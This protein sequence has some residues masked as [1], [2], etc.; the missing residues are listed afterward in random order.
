MTDLCAEG[1][2][3]TQHHLLVDAGQNA[4]GSWHVIMREL[5]HN[6]TA[7]AV[8]TP[9]TDEVVLGDPAL[10]GAGSFCIS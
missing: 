4:D 3:G 6:F 8:V 2:A 9:V 5:Q 7:A 10:G 1:T